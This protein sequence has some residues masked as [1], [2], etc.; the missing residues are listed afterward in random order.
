LCANNHYEPLEYSNFYKIFEPLIFSEHY[1]C[2]KFELYVVAG[3]DIHNQN[4]R[5]LCK[6]VSRYFF[7]EVSG[8]LSTHSAQL[9]REIELLSIIN[10]NYYPGLFGVFQRVSEAYL[11]NS[12]GEVNLENPTFIKLLKAIIRFP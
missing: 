4:Q 8:D 7:G 10:S 11:T 6:I 1:I 2:R 9:L 3:V 5:I 12:L